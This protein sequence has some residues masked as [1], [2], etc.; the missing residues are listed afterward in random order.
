MSRKT[1]NQVEA[2]GTWWDIAESQIYRIESY[3]VNDDEGRDKIIS[4]MTCILY[5]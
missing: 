2:C 3:K 5:V 1:K 4:M